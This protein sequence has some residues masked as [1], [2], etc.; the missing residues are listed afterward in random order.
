MFYG[1]FNEFD[2]NGD[3]V[4]SKKEMRRFVARFLDI[5]TLQ[6]SDIINLVN[7][8]WF[9]FDTDRSGKLNRKESLRFLNA[10]LTNQGHQTVSG[11]SFNRFF[12]EFDVNKDGHISK[13][14]MARFLGKF[15]EIP[16]VTDKEVDEIALLLFD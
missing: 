7:Q 16:R 1:I 9:E 6:L 11:I 14:E 8:I 13:T 3:G 15:F 10:F 2:S 5:P 4:L 12:A